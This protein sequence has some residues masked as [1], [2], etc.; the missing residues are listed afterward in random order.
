MKISARNQL[1]GTVK[2][3]E[4]GAVNSEVTIELSGGEQIAS[5]ITNQAVKSLDLK[6]GST[7]Y[8]IIKASTVML[9]VD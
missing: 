7:T 5:I 1:K 6:V 9:A 2:S 8:A 4:T 3:I